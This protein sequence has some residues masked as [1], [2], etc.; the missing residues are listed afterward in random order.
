MK[1]K[2]LYRVVGAIEAVPF[3]LAA[4]TVFSEPNAFNLLMSESL[5][6]KV[7]G[8][9]YLGVGAVFSGFVA[10]GVHGMV[11]AKPF[12]MMIDVATIAI[13]GEGMKEI[14][15]TYREIEEAGEYEMSSISRIVIHI[16]NQKYPWL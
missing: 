13:N 4:Y 9:L 8:A 12:K 7:M 3:G 15:K 14:N 2:T 10:D 16:F 6:S 5:E 1:V 11:R